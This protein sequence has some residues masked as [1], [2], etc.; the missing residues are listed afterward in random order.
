MKVRHAKLGKYAFTGHTKEKMES[1]HYGMPWHYLYVVVNQTDVRRNETWRMCSS[2][3]SQHE[4]NLLNI[5]NLLSVAELWYP[6]LSEFSFL[7]FDFEFEMFLHFKLS[8]L[9]KGREFS[10][11]TEFLS[12]LVYNDLYIIQRLYLQ[13]LLQRSELLLTNLKEGSGG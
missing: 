13:K 8:A 6:P 11:N 4:P 3:S 12:S 5:L 10:I 9:I 7:P 2:A 1:D